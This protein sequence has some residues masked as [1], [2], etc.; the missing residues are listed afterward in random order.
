ML[1]EVYNVIMKFFKK[2]DDNRMDIVDEYG[3]W[4]IIRR[5]SYALTVKKVIDKT[6]KKLKIKNGNFNLIALYEDEKIKGLIGIKGMVYFQEQIRDAD[7]YRAFKE[8][9]TDYFTLGE[10]RLSRLR[11]CNQTFLFFN[12]NML[13]RKTECEND[14]VKLL[15]P[16]KGVYTDEIPYSMKDLFLKLVERNSNSSCN[17]VSFNLTNGVFEAIFSCK[18][19]REFDVRSL[20]D[21]FSYF[22][23]DNPII[24][25]KN[26]NNATEISISIQKFKTKYLIP[27]L[28]GNIIAS[29]IV[30]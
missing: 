5:N 23:D 20:Y 17:S 28:W 1:I 13:V 2:K 24:T 27:L 4:L 9:S 18:S 29:N 12:I 15:F 26:S 7:F 21:S 8:S 22:T 14:S 6:L 3:E 25:F 19:K 30:C 11:V 16:P 10:M